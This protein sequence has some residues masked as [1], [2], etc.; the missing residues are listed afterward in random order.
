[1][2]KLIFI[3]SLAILSLSA[4]LTSAQMS[5]S[6]FYVYAN[7]L[8]DGKVIYNPETTTSIT[9][10]YG[11]AKSGTVYTNASIQLIYYNYSTER[12]IANRFVA[13]GYWQNNYVY[14]TLTG[15]IP[16]GSNPGLIYLKVV[17][18]PGGSAINSTIQY[19]MIAALTKK[20]VYQFS[21][22]TSGK[23]ALNRNA[24]WNYTVS[25]WQ[26][27]GQPFKAYSSPQASSIAIYEYYNATLNDRIYK[28][29]GTGLTG[30]TL[31][32]L[33]FY[34]YDTSVTGTIPIYELFNSSTN[35]H[36]YSPVTTGY[37]GFSSTGVAF[38]AFSN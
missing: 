13:D 21:G 24:S 35:D 6:S 29:S 17:P 16:A 5:I 27:N 7:F 25:G 20:N 36:I 32:N 31:S 37:P 10:S 8:D 2:R 14:G 26:S 28:S 11:V 30:Y 34:A 4:K 38:Y 22:I 15:N 19:D 3:I 12:I 9:A 23:H 18:G 33:A 1:M